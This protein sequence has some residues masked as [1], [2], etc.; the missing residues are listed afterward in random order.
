[1]FLMISLI[2]NIFLDIFKIVLYLVCSYDVMVIS[3][4]D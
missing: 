1:M 4:F 3:Q 2:V